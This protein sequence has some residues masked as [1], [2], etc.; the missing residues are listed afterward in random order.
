MQLLCQRSWGPLES[1]LELRS[2]PL[3]A[4]GPGELR[5]EILAAPIHPV[6]RLRSLGAYA[7]PLAIPGVPGIEGVGRIVELGPALSVQPTLPKVGDLCLLPLRFG[8]YRSQA[9]V[10]AREV[11]PLPEG[12]DPLQASMLII[13]PLSAELLLDESPL[14]PGDSFLNLPASG[15]VGQCLMALGKARGFKSINLV[16]NEARK[17]EWRSF[18]TSLDPLAEL[19]S[20]ESWGHL[21]IPPS[22]KAAFDGVGGLYTQTLTASL[23]SGST[24]LVY[25]AASRKAPQ[26]GLSELIFKGVDVRGFWLNRSIAKL[27]IQGTAQRIRALAELMLQG[28]LRMKVAATFGLHEHRQAFEVAKDPKTVGK[29]LLIP[30]K[31]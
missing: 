7:Q 14:V 5:L 18:L 30:N 6:D 31:S 9:I 10:A 19:H 8:S 22:Y 2:A 23:E 13:N 12:L 3:R 29:V 11:F 15:A 26:L 25:G 20:V 16:R 27:G 1:A 24:L 21:R 28:Q 4:L 17:R